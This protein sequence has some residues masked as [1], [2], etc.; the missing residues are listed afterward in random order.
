MLQTKFR[1][2][3]QRHGSTV[4][5]KASGIMRLSDVDT[6]RHALITEHQRQ[7]ARA[8]LVDLRKVF[9]ALSDDDWKAI[10]AHDMTVAPADMP[11]GL[12]VDPAYESEAWRYCMAMMQGGHTRLPFIDAWDA[13]AWAGLPRSVM[14]PTRPFQTHSV[15]GA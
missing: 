7:P 10:A 4:L 15:A 1:H 5:A 2:C 6:L 12:L 11:A 8:A 3:V 13:L 14:P 9:L